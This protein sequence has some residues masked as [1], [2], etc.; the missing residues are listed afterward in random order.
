MWHFVVTSIYL[1]YTNE[2]LMWGAS[3]Y[4]P[5]FANWDK[6]INVKPLEHLA[7]SDLYL[8]LVQIRYKLLELY[9]INYKKYNVIF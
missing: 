6:S 2:M 7:G 5:N 9:C 4:L 3:G 1:N 8:S